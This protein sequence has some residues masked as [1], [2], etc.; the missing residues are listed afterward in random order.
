MPDRSVRSNKS[1]FTHRAQ[2]IL[3]RSPVRI[4]VSD[5]AAS[6][7]ADADVVMLCIGSQ[8]V[9]DIVGLPPATVVTSISTNAPRA[10]E[11]DPR[12]CRPWM[13]V[14]LPPGGD[15]GGRGLRHRR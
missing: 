7:V 2:S 11:I 4:T 1:A 3:R 10:H 15:G 6:A 8:P 12:H 5:T 9:I 13:S 14:R